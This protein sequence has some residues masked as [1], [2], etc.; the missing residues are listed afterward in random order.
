MIYPIPDI[1]SADELAQVRGLLERLPFAD[2]RETVGA[3]LHASKRNL[4]MPSHGAGAAEAVQAAQIV[5]AGLIRCEPFMQLA[6]PR[7]ITPILFNRYEP[8]M[9]YGPHVD[10]SLM[11]EQPDRFRCDLSF[12]VFLSAPDEYE[13][14]ELLINCDG[15]TIAAKQPA[16]HLVL[17]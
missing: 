7:R 8:G 9:F 17:Y 3:A 4:E 10:E 1:L 12:S 13:G 6:M 15:P 5:A 11:G 2:G 14:G 16:G